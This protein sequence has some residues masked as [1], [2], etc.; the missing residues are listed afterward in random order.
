MAQSLTGTMIGIS[1]VCG[2]GRLCV[3]PICVLVAVFLSFPNSPSTQNFCLFNIKFVSGATEVASDSKPV[4]E[5]ALEATF[6]KACDFA[7]TLDDLAQSEQLKIYK[8]Y[9]QA[10]FG[11]APA[12]NENSGLAANM[13][14]NAWCSVRG[15][16]REKAREAYIQTLK[17][18]APHW[19]AEAARKRRCRGL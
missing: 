17:D 16:S 10:N 3:M 15:M 9:K 6:E 5:E 1:R 7:R 18:N 2:F 8:Y 13:K 19:E 11:D 4:P 14:Y 12:E